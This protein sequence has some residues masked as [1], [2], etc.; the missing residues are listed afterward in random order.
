MIIIF[1]YGT[2][3][4]GAFPVVA[5]ETSSVRL[6]AKS[7]ALGFATQYFASWAFNFFV[8]YMFNADAANWGGKCGFF[9][10]GLCLIA[11]VVAWLEIPELKGRTYSEIDVMFE[12]KLSTRL[13]KSYV[14][15]H[16][17]EDDEKSGSKVEHII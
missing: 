3:V 12:K 13:F 2:G 14:V 9:F 10:T 4:G 15:D 5:S 6:R 16:I 17:L 11:L 7:N 1:I 8:P